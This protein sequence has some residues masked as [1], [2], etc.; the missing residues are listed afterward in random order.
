MLSRLEGSGTEDSETQ[1]IR[2]GGTETKRWARVVVGHES[3]QQVA[4]LLSWKRTGAATKSLELSY[5]LS[6]AEMRL[7]AFS[8][9][10][11]KLT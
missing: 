9:K 5:L 8:L 4:P 3:F 10:L 2:W 7:S 11:A 6:S 1:Q